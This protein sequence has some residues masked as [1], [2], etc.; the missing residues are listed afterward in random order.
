MSKNPFP[1]TKN[2]KNLNDA[3]MNINYWYFEGMECPEGEIEANWK[4][5]I[6]EMKR[7]AD[8]NMR[9]LLT[10]QDI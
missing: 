8:R 9:N 1:Y 4:T 10:E 7:D 2:P 6:R 5:F 3:Q